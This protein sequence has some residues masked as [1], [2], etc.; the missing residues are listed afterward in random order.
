MPVGVA[1]AS[2]PELFEPM[3]RGPIRARS[4]DGYGAQSTSSKLLGLEAQQVKEAYR[5]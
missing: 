4:A 2:V 5:R 3:L 1:G